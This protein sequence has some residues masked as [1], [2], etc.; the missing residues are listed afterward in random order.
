M[1]ERPYI[2]ITNDDSLDAEG[3]KVLI[4]IMEQYGDLLVVAPANS[5][6]G[7]SHALT[8]TTP[9][10]IH[11]EE[12][13]QQKTVYRCFGTPVDCVKIA[14]NQFA[15]RKPDL[16]VSGINHG[17]N[18]SVSAIYSG[19]VAAAREGCLN[20]IASIAF[21][22]LDF[23]KNANFAPFR[24]WIEKTVKTVLKEGMPNGCLLNVNFPCHD[25]ENLKEMKICRQAKGA[26]VEQFVKRSD[27]MKRDYYWLTG[28]FRNDEPDAEDTDEWL[29]KNNYIS[30]VPL[31]I[32]ATDF[33]NIP[34]FKTLWE[35]SPG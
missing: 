15:K 33:D 28:F 27:P 1:N 7:Q 8:F 4:S 13:S 9:M 17:S 22:T 12:E 14:I 24:K 11:L 31:K 16:L 10:R 29:L 30:A 23:S 34:Y 18:S 25:L 6:S 3:I 35:Q 32:E 20:G 21:S 2:L 5:Q 26:W 19:T